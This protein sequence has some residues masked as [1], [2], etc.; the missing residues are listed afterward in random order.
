[1]AKQTSWPGHDRIPI[2]TARTP[3]PK[4]MSD[5]NA[6]DPTAHKTTRQ[7]IPA[8]KHLASLLFILLS[9]LTPTR[10]NPLGDG[11]LFGWALFPGT[12]S[13]ILFEDASRLWDASAERGEMPDY[14]VR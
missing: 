10:K 12:I 5:H 1:M 2:G 7:R 13:R 3:R 4:A 8:K 6:H 9:R 14:R 11:G